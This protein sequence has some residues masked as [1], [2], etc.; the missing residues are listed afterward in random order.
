MNATTT[1]RTLSTTQNPRSTPGQARGLKI[2]TEQ[3][4]HA[5]GATT[6]VYTNVSNDFKNK[7]LQ[8]ALARVY[9]P[10]ATDDAQQSTEGRLW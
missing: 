5:W 8:T 9:Q 10:Q 4:G 2:M 3:V 7:T 6:A 1:S